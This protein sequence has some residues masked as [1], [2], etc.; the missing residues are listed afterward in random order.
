M[1]AIAYISLVYHRL[2][3]NPQVLLACNRVAA[4]PGYE[5]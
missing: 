1:Y 2:N 4:A 3:M 5:R